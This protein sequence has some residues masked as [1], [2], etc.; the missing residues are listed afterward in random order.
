MAP[1]YPNECPPGFPNRLEV[2]SGDTMFSIAKRFK[3][4]LSDLIAANPHISDPNRIR[5]GDILCVP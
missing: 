2:V 3:V 5:P 4:K 1:C